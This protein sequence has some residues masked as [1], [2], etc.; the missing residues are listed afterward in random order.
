MIQPSITRS[1]MTNSAICRMLPTMTPS[2]KFVLPLLDVEMTVE[3]SGAL[4]AMGIITAAMNRSVVW[5]AFAVSSTL[6]RR[7]CAH[8]V[9]QT[10]A[11]MRLMTAAQRWTAVESL[12][13]SFELVFR[14]PAGSS[15][16]LASTKRWE[17]VLSW[18]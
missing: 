1:G 17:C 11:M 5:A 15:S 4:L 9:M 16:C 13:P 18:K 12:V 10:V 8:T 3:N 6:S 2:A 7:R 14:S